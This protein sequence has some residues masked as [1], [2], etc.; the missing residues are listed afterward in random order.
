MSNA[1]EALRH[2]HGVELV[3]ADFVWHRGGTLSQA[4]RAQIQADE[5]AMLEAAAEAVGKTGVPVTTYSAPGEPA[6]VLLECARGAAM[7]VHPRTTDLQRGIRSTNSRTGRRARTA[8]TTA[9]QVGPLRTDA[10]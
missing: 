3:H 2:G 7:L 8:T 1:E 5:R 10:T 4:A 6:D 9:C